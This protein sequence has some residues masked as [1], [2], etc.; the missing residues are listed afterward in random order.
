M[1]SYYNP[2]IGSKSRWLV[3]RGFLT[4]LAISEITRR[5]SQ[6]ALI[7]FGLM[8]STMVIIGSLIVGDSM[9]YLVYSSTYD[10]LGE[11]DFIVSSGEFF[12]YDYYND[13]NQNST[14]ENVIDKHAPVILLPCSLKAKTSNLR[15]NKAQ[16]FGFDLK[17]LTFGKLTRVSNNKKITNSE[18][19]L[20]NKE[21]IINE[22]L[23][24]KL[25]LNENDAVELSVKNPAFALDSVYSS[26]LGK[27]SKTASMTVK[28]IVD[29]DGLGRLQLD[30][31]THDTSNI[32]MSLGGLQKLLGIENKINTILISAKGDEHTG[33]EHEDAAV[34][35]IELCLDNSI[36]LEELG[37][38]LRQTKLQYLRLLNSEDIFFDEDIYDLILEYEQK[39]NSEFISSPVLTYFVNSVFSNRTRLMVNYSTMTG[40]DFEKDEVFGDFSIRNTSVTSGSTNK[41]DL[42]NNE[43][44]LIDWLADQL[45]AVVGDTITVEYM[46]LDRL[47]NIYNTSAEFTVKYIISLSGKASDEELMSVIPGLEGAQDCSDWDPPFPVDLSRLTEEDRIY[48]IENHGT[49]KAYINLEQAQSLWST[50]LGAFTT[51]KLNTSSTSDDSDLNQ[52]K[53]RLDLYLNSQIGYSDGGLIIDHVKSDALATARGMS[54]FPAMFLTFGIA[55]ILAGLALIVTIFLILADSRKY[56]LGLG[57]ALGLKKAQV[58]KLFMIEG[59]I[60]AGIAGILGIIFGLFL[61]WGLIT[62]LNSIWSS[63]VEG[64]TIPFYFKPVSLLIGFLAGFI[65]T[66]ITIF[67][68]SRHIAKLN[69]I[70][71][72]QN[73]PTISKTTKK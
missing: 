33:L 68:T 24:S 70:S 57:R 54:I 17:L 58:V 65:I 64:Y 38:E 26:R 34:E 43:I 72:L 42:T 29:N 41:I 37:F 47:Y 30:G 19:T 7:V 6:A 16:V 11:V 61:G 49:P 8:I 36:G 31:R 67:F 56:D 39:P 45:D 59:L 4:N 10:N 52:L 25:N 15:E 46:A 44:I 1:D 50:N 20:G 35:A 23:A 73:L 62:T 51:I 40:L 5:K 69:I 18:L 9:E 27:N 21:V 71:A 14:I 22:V 48:W 3:L 66:I 28:F 53:N 60:Y 55:I 13:I 2:Q 32:F 12:D 63:A